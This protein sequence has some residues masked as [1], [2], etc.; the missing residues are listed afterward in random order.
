MKIFRRWR[1]EGEAFK[2]ALAFFTRL[3]VK[4]TT[5]RPEAA[6][7]YLP[8]IGFLLGGILFGLEIALR[9]YWG[10]E[11]RALAL[12]L[13]Q[14]LGANYFHFDGLMDT[15]DALYAGEDRQRR[16]EV[17]KTPEVGALGFL[18]GFFFLLGEYL[19]LKILLS[20]G[21]SEVLFFKPLF[22]RLGL[23]AGV[24]FGKPARS[25]GLGR[26]FLSRQ[27]KRRAGPAFLFLFVF[28][29][30]FF[31]LKVVVVSGGALMLVF[32]FT[33]KFGGLT[34]DLLGAL[35]EVSELLFLALLV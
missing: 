26:L 20:E 16:L 30:W 1:E 19:L 27:A 11:V 3:P 33:R 28:L 12:L 23:L 13:V 7:T 2:T 8:L 17:L 5:F 22:G 29:F 10:P 35:C 31:G 18:F 34:G 6:L 21:L 14:Y 9:P 32:Y 25:E 24:V 4:E 15:L